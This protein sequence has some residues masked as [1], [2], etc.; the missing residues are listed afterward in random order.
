M[1]GRRVRHTSVGMSSLDAVSAPHS[2][3]HSAAPRRRSAAE[4]PDWFLGELRSDQAGETGAVWI[5]RGM[6]ATARDPAVRSFAE[7]HLSTEAEHLVL[8]DGLLPRRARSRLLP[9]W[10]LAGWVTGALPAAVGAQAAFAT[11]EAVETF[12]DRHYQDQ[13]DRLAEAGGHAEL[14]AL[15]A[16]CQADERDHRDE[17]AHLAGAD[18]PIWLRAWCRLVGIGSAGAVALARKV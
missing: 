13:L 5:Y 2:A 18:R 9:L 1:A 15:L 4:V 16:A 3:P 7:R 8:I 10:R 6:L 12:V 17:G 11:V 14:C